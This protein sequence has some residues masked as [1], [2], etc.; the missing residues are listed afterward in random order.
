MPNLNPKQFKTTLGRVGTD[1]GSLSF[2]A[3]QIMG[4]D[5]FTRILG[6]D[7][8]LSSSAQKTYNNT[9]NIKRPQGVRYQTYN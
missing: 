7:K 4:N 6:D 9:K 3:A 1:R 8:E 5:G 2:Q